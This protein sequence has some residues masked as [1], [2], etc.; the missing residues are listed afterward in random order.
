MRGAIP[1]LPKYLFM[2][3][4]LVKNRENFT[5]Y[6]GKDR[7]SSGRGLFQC[8]LLPSDWGWWV[9]DRGKVIRPSVFT[10]LH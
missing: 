6:T 7:R 4:C 3:W 5:F 2:A 10:T 1:T 8:T 9:G